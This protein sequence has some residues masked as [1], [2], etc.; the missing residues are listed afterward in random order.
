MPPSRH[1]NSCSCWIGRE[2][3]LLVV[4]SGSKLKR[5]KRSAPLPLQPLRPGNLDPEPAEP[6]VG[7]VAR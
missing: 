3:A 6:H 5:S 2:L 7:A 4:R 1:P